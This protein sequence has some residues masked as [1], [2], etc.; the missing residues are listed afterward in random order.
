MLSVE[1]QESKS[2]LSI[3]KGW[4]RSTKCVPLSVCKDI[5]Q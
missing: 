5:A 1:M 2:A 3:H 4:S